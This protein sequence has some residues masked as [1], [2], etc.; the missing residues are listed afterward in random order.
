MYSARDVDDCLYIHNN[1]NG[2]VSKPHVLATHDMSVVGF[3]APP[4][5][6]PPFQTEVKSVAQT[7]NI[8][9]FILL[10]NGEKRLRGIP[11]GGITLLLALVGCF[12][13]ADFRSSILFYFYHCGII[14]LRIFI[15]HYG[16]FS[17]WSSKLT[18]SRL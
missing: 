14:L 6:P 8:P 17:S 2:F 16:G 15:S 7:R 9:P 18:T 13:P 12:S 11:M 1:I 4:P 5:L 10:R 3:F